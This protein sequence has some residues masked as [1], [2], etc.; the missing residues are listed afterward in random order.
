MNCSLLY[1][2]WRKERIWFIFKIKN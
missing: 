1:Y 2:L